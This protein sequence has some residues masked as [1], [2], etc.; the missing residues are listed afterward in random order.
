MSPTKFV[1]TVHLYQTDEA[2][3]RILNGDGK[4]QIAETIGTFTFKMPGLEDI[5]LIE[6][7]RDAMLS[8]FLPQEV[9]PVEKEKAAGDDSPPEDAPVA[10]RPIIRPAAY[11]DVLVAA[12]F[13]YQVI[14]APDEWD[15]KAEERPVL[16]AIYDAYTEGVEENRGKNVRQ[17]T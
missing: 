13:P 17:G 8:A 5:A 14:K 6:L 11:L 7:R 15:W 4:P 12:T 3:N 16:W 1:K 2:G 10:P 9:P